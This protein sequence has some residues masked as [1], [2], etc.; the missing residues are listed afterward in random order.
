MS[1]TVSAKA[2]EPAQD[3]PFLP[4]G[5]QWIEADDIA[6]VV[7]VLQSDLLTYGPQ[8]AAFEQDLARVVEARFGVA[9]SNGTSA[10]HVA[11]AA[12]DV[13]PG[14]V[15]IAPAM[16][17]LST[18][19]AARFCN[20]EIVFADV[21]PVTGLLTADT[22]IEAITRAGPK[23]KAVLPV[24][25]AGRSCDMAAIAP[26]ARA[27]GLS[28]VEDACHALGTRIDGHAVGA[29]THSD[30]CCF[31]F[32]GVKTIASGEGGMVTT[33]D[34]ALAE[35]MRRL[36]N[37]G[38]THD[39]ALMTDP[40]LSLDGEGARNPWSYEQL[41]LGF[42]YRMTDIA[43]A[44]GR[45]QLAKLPRFVARRRA[46]AERYD[47]LLAPLANLVAPVRNPAGQSV[48]L[49]LY[50]IHLLGQ[51]QGRRAAIMR[52]LAARGIGAQVHYI[53]MYRHP[54]F[55]ARYGPMSLPGA[56]AYYAGALALPLFPA[57]ADGD[58]DR[59]VAELAK[60]IDA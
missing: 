24:H 6:A 52:A 12:L 25:L 58:V 39:P 13:G 27:A 20:A 17:F 56:E 29:S 30:A 31:S 15:C 42:N 7:A 37:H 26:V 54:Y 32:H 38:V 16:T 35:R 49:H 45:S 33:N 55:V 34:Q 44:L 1:T 23:A 9:C 43:A 46:L 3:L 19:T 60:A 28:I 21:D 59:V 18:A 22:L 47:D 11:L 8:M 2:P 5:R 57:M 4:Y 36:R 53:P 51:L 48:S 41:E 14:D 40:A 10:L 50:V